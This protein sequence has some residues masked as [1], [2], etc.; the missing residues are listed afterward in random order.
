MSNV[1]P[2]DPVEQTAKVV[3][4]REINLL[5]NI[6]ELSVLTLKLRMVRDD[7]DARPEHTQKAAQEFRAKQREVSTLVEE[8]TEKHIAAIEALTANEGIAEP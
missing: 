8:L 2:A 5:Q 6:R 7:I 1:E 3:R 4:N